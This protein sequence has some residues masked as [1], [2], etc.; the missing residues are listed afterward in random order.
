M[1]R[2]SGMVSGP[3]AVRMMHRAA[4]VYVEQTVHDLLGV[5]TVCAVRADAVM[6][7]G[8]LLLDRTRR[9]F[10]EVGGFVVPASTAAVHPGFIVMTA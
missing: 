3:R 9:R 1:D 4:R 8:R 6:S 2:L 5:H 10:G 7:A